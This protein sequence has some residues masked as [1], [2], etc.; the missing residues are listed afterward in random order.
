MADKSFV[1][2]IRFKGDVNKM[3]AIYFLEEIV[4]RYFNI[5]FKELNITC[6]DK[7]KPNWKIKSRTL[8]FKKSNIKKIE[9]IV[10]NNIDR[11]INI[12]FELV[13]LKD[14]YVFKSRDVEVSA[15]CQKS[16]STNSL[17]LIV[18]DQLSLKT[19]WM[20]FIEEIVSFVK[21]QNCKVIY[22]FLFLLENLK[23]PAFYVE[24]IGS[25]ELSVSEQKSVNLWREEK[26]NCEEKIW[27]IFGINILLLNTYKSISINEI[28]KIVGD[29]NVKFL[30]DNLV[31][32]Q[33]KEKLND[34]DV[35]KYFGSRKDLFDYFK[36]KDLIV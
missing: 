24:G 29:Q 28:I 17:N 20:D 19:S 10:S 36:S 2:S 30:N 16:D 23:M 4:K 9:Q 13:T 33:L 5:S 35:L 1:L 11:N 34:F 12:D 15:I 8:K 26:E 21:N 6:L 31:M 7:S 22:G 18:N 27:D 25:N 32:I 3:K 14:G